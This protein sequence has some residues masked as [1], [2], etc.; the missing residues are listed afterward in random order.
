MSHSFHRP[1][2]NTGLT[3]SPICF[4]GNVFG[5]SLDE[6]ASLA[7]LDALPDHG[8]NFIDTADA[9]SAWVDGNQGGESEALIG[10]WFKTRGRRSDVVL[11][12]KVGSPMATSP[13]GLKADTIVRGVEASLQR[14]QTDYIDL[15]QSH[16]DDADTPIDETL[17]AFDKLV[18]AGKVRA[19]GASNF[20]A[21]RL[22]ASLDAS[23]ANGWAAYT[24]LQPLYNLMDREAF[25]QDL[26]AVC[27]ENDIAVIPYFSLASGFLT[28]KYRTDAD[29]A[30]NP[31][32]GERVRKY[33][34]P[35]G[36]R[37][38]AALDT[39]AA[40]TG[41]SPASVALAWLMARPAI[42]APIASA[43]SLTQLAALSAAMSLTLTEPQQALLTTASAP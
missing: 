22:K 2:G 42:G 14:L 16:R 35:R 28:G 24:T 27:L 11:A 6:A 8:I 32:R 25:E 31:T 12:T 3:V 43:T 41:A 37:V 40:E 5:W 23:A 7:M 26:M 38:V 19:L 17:E 10:T 18:R 34:T 39:V 9:Y 21:D 13:G 1:L 33:L 4:G 15:Y 20:S 36:Q 29:I 30:A